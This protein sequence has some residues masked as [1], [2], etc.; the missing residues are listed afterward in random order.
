MH[1]CKIRKIF[2]IVFFLVVL[3]ICIL[4][5]YAQNGTISI[6]YRGAG[7]YYLGDSIIFDGKN[8]VGNTTVITITGPGLPHEGVP[9]YNLTGVPGTGNTIASRASGTWTYIWDSTQAVGINNLST[10]RYT[11]TVF[12]LS[13]PRNTASIS[14]YLIKPDFYVALSP[15][16]AAPDDYVQISGR[17]KTAADNIDINVLDTSGNPVHTFNAPISADGYFNYGF[18]VDM[19]PGPYA[20]TISSPSISNSLAKT[21]VVTATNANGT[22]AETASTTTVVLPVA[23]N[24]GIPVAP[25]VTPG[26]SQDTGILDISS[27][28]A[29]ASVYLDSAMAGKTPLILNAV[30]PGTHTVSIKYPGY[31]SVS[32]DVVVAG[33]KTRE[34]APE[35]VKAPFGLPLSPLTTIAGC[36]GGTALFLA[37]RQRK[38]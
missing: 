36:I 2:S 33:G 24:T 5:A 37:V 17:V 25:Q 29:G 22:I 11:F 10:S 19:Q 3:T 30:T 14:V 13:N 21:L 26:V 16:P 23:N 27:T 4:P 31:L 18:H 32:I 20:V 7:D 8:T 35:L 28:P 6:T 1:S 9:P 34:I 12:D 15:N 38:Q